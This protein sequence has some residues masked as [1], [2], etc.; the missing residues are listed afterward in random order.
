MSVGSSRSAPSEPDVDLSSV[1][2]SSHPTGEA[3]VPALHCSRLPRG[4]AVPQPTE[5]LRG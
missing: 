1:W 3:D 2:R 5:P 4:M